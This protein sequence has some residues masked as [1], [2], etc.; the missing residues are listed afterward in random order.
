MSAIQTRTALW[1]SASLSVDDFVCQVAPHRH[2]VEEVSA[3]HCVVFIRS[4]AFVRTIGS[5]PLLADPTHVLFFTRGEPYQ[6]TH[7]IGGG[8]RCTIVTVAPE[9]LL[10]I[11]R[12]HDPGWPDDP[13]APFRGRHCLSTAHAT[14]LHQ[15]LLRGLRCAKADPLAAHEL[16][17]DLLDE[18]LGAGWSENSGDRAP[19]TKASAR[20][21]EL[22]EAAKTALS[23]DYAAPPS[24]ERLAETMGC[25]PFHLCRSFSRTVGVPLRRYRDRLRLRLALD[26]LATGAPDL[27]ALALDLGYADHSHFTNAFRREFGHPPS[28]L[29]P[30]KLL[31][32]LE[33]CDRARRM[34]R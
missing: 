27:T 13:G 14:L 3:A 17:L 28:A 29:R 12:R 34:T 5:E 25:S 7:P 6:V 18:V 31:G 24:L 10:E 2:G 21:R 11:G 9:T 20:A 26:K 15:A 33:N 1:S 30:A 32:R 19:A 4:G 16:T 23:E 22:A 8:D